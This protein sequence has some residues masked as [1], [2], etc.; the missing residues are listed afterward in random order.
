M[1]VGKLSENK[2]FYDFTDEMTDCQIENEL[3]VTKYIHEAPCLLVQSP[4]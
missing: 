4:Q 1:Q 2:L 3:P